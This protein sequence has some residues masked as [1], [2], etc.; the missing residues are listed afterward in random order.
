MGEENAGFE[1]GPICRALIEFR[2]GEGFSCGVGM[3]VAAREWYKGTY[4]PMYIVPPRTSKF[5]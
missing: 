3:I 5:S 1:D 2:R 4:T